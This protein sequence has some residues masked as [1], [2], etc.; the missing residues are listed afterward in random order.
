V[1][2]YL[3]L[4]TNVLLHFRRPDE[5]DW[6]VL[7]DGEE[8]EIVLV[9]PVLREIDR[10]KATHPVKRVKQRAAAIFK[11]FGTMIGSKEPIRL[12]EGVSLSFRRQDPLIDFQTHKLRTGIVD[13]EVVASV[14]EF[15]DEHDGAQVLIVTD[16][17]AMRIL[18]PGHGI[19]AKPPP[20]EC[21]LPDEPD[22]AD[23]EARELKVQLAEY[24]N[25]QPELTL[26]FTDGNAR[27]RKALPEVQLI[28]DERVQ[29]AIFHEEM[30][31]KTERPLFISDE[32]DEAGFGYTRDQALD[33]VMYRVTAKR[34][35]MLKLQ[36]A[37]AHRSRTVTLTLVLRN[38]GRAPATDIDI[39]LELTDPNASVSES[40]G[41]D[42]VDPSEEAE[43][44]GRVSAEREEGGP[45]VEHSE[46]ELTPTALAPVTRYHWNSLKQGNSVRLAPLH[47]TFR[48]RKAAGSFGIRYTISYAEGPEP[49]AGRLDVIVSG[50]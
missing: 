35:H 23:V 34:E 14:L 33:Y 42:P 8:A 30:V 50:Q 27:Q 39:A 16:D 38:A 43:Q 24:R 11:W 22:P 37:R 25:R 2:T 26:L 7:T 9:L 18:A 1:P 49:V 17:L 29:A 32:H 48:T 41:L 36:K 6:R 15:Q 10:H 44:H 31:A 19:E 21:R 28:S 4:D 12:R 13:D 3:F 20:E 5:I 46:T 45:C 40:E 47:V